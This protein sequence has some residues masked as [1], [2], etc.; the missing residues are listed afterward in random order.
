MKFYHSYIQKTILY[1]IAHIFSVDK[2][3]SK[4][5]IIEITS[6]IYL[7]T[8]KIHAHLKYTILN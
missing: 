8:G 6:M 3:S 2:G 7:I 1:N 5:S 4:K